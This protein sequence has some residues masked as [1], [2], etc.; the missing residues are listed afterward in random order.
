MSIFFRIYE[1][2][3][4]RARV[5]RI[6]LDTQLRQLFQGL[7]G[8]SSDS[9]DF[10]DARW[11]DSQP[12]FTEELDQWEDQWGLVESGLTEQQRRDRLEGQW[13][14]HG[15]QSPRYIQDI[16]QG[17]GFTGVFIH[18]WWVVPVVGAPVVRNP[19]VFLED[20]TG[21]VF[22]VACG[23]LLSECGEAGAEA[24][25]AASPLGYPLV[26]KIATSVTLFLGCGDPEMECGEA[27]A[28]CGDPLSTT[29]APV[30]YTVPSDPAL[31]PYF[32]YFGGP[33][34]PDMAD[35]QG[36][37]RDEFENLLLKLCPGQLWI[38]VLVNYT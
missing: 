38:G 11:G 29:F 35:V 2:L 32:I 22:L 16:V 27:V 17:A 19:N 6:K 5:W 33:T 3:L 25:E 20:G 24:G 34:F 8:V 18:E 36:A 21:I 30:V 13:K 4:P 14:M 9:V 28:I 31:W 15:G 37:R 7:T 1:H 12:Q 26:N 10:L 23:E